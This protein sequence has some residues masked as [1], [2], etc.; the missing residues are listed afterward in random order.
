M[1]QIL[2]DIQLIQIEHHQHIFCEERL[3]FIFSTVQAI[4]FH[5]TVWKLFAIVGPMT[6]ILLFVKNVIKHDVQILGNQEYVS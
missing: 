6:V 1:S 4:L 2:T 3:Y 5:K